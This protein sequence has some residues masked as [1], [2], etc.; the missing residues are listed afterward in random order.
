[1]NRGAFDRLVTFKRTTTTTNGYNEQVSSGSTEI[2][3]GYARV[4]FGRA[5]EQRLAA[6]EAGSQA[7]TFELVTTTALR[8]VD[9]TNLIEFDGDDW[10]IKNIEPLD[11]TIIR[12][13]AVRNR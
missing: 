11:R 12:F 6:Q 5:D 10:N 13:T 7:A 3:K 2:E 4:R 9:L 1:M 8:S